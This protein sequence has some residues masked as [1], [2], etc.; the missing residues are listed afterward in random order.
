MDPVSLSLLAVGT[1]GVVSYCRNEHKRKV[2]ATRGPMTLT[3]ML[4]NLDADGVMTWPVLAVHVRSAHMAP[5]LAQDSLLVRVKVGEEGASVC[6]DTEETRAT[7]PAR[8]AASWFVS[9]LPQRK[10][11]QLAEA[12]FGSTCLF[13]GQRKGESFIRI[14]LMQAGPRGKTLAKASLRVTCSGLRQFAQMEETE[15]QLYGT[16]LHA[17]KVVG[18]INVGADMC[19][20]QR[21]SLPQ[22]LHLLQLQKRNGAFRVMPRLFAEGRLAD[23]AEQGACALLGQAVDSIAPEAEQN[24]GVV[25]GAVEEDEEQ[26][27]E[28]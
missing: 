14:R 21:D 9:R 23:D 17:H 2:K 6:C 18:R 13:Q 27:E 3:E 12:D 8:P 10:E 5:H 22:Y 20:V 19:A 16:G 26:E 28:Q 11:P 24:C 4:A 25:E 15:L 7:L 1:V